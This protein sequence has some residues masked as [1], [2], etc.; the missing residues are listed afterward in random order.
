MSLNGDNNIKNIPEFFKGKNIFVTGGS[1]YIGKV[2][3]EKLLRSCPDLEN[4][5][6]LIRPKRNK[7]I[8]ERIESLTNV[9]L[10][11]KLKSQNDAFQKKIIPVSGNIM[12]LNLGI[13]EEDRTHLIENINIIYH[14]AASVRFDDH[15]KDAIL[16]NTRSARELIHLANQ[17][18]ALDVYVHVS[19][20][21][22]NADKEVIEEKIYPRHNW[23]DAIELAET[24]EESIIE[25]MT[26]K[27]IYPL[28]N[29]Y[30]FTKSLAECVVYELCTNKIP[31]VIVRPSIVLPTIL[32]PC[33]GWIDNFN[34]PTGLN[35][36]GYKG[37][38]KILYGNPDA[39]LDYVFADNVAKAVII[40][41]WKKALEP[42]TQNVLICNASSDVKY[43]FKTIDTFGKLAVGN[44]PRTYI[45]P[46]HVNITECWLVFF[47]LVLTMHMIP[48]LLIDGFLLLR[49]KK[50]RLVRIQR[51]IYIANMAV[52]TFLRNEWEIINNNYHALDKV[53]LSEDRANFSFLHTRLETE[54]EIRRLAESLMLP[55][56]KY[57]LHEK[58]K[59]TEKE[60]KNYARFSAFI[61]VLKYGLIGMV[62]YLLIWKYNLPLRTYQ[63]IY[64]Y[65]QNLE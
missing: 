18:K 65:I 56:R 33:Y 39:H 54:D 61:E 2:L 30:T 11:D 12:K 6:V 3:I 10:F 13:S 57:L 37:L 60:I 27:Y 22:T 62:S 23:Q 46:C 20:A 9:P 42:K 26:R 48:A 58:P 14:C 44:P 19:T 17:I 45:W 49:K 1:G 32:E 31:A 64:G 4:I 34:G 59:A 38:L 40:S 5:Y 21:Y 52:I 43:S 24:C 51:K 47:F 53:L 16:N 36:A 25:V 8:Q 29:T 63:S 15:L 28:P 41:S 55:V 7:S 35:V 50:S